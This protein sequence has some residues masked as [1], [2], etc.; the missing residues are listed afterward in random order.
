MYP[1]LTHHI[2]E[3]KSARIPPTR[4]QILDG[5]SDYI[6][7]KSQKR[8]EVLLNFICTHNSRRSHLSQIWA[9]TLAEYF[10]IPKICCFSG[11]T[12]ATALY[13]AVADTLVEQGF[14]V[15]RLSE[16]DN[17]IYAVKHS[18]N[19]LPVV[20]FSKTYD[21]PFNPKSRF[22]AI[23]TCGEADRGCPFVSGAEVRFSIPF[24]DPKEFDDSP[25]KRE[26]YR[27]RSLQIAA[28]LYYVFA[29]CT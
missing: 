3:L 11:G 17:P 8:E 28:E 24:R 26:K 19:A 1:A 9:Q 10:G 14:N 23:M 25:L 4:M 16:G 5:L 6:R 29:Q 27:E 2:T 20:A 13:P 12:E 21:H 7:S 22:A 15:I 18:D